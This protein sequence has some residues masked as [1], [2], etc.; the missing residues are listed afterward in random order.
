MKT[1]V[2]GSHK[3]RLT[4]ALLMSTHN[5][6]FHGKLEK[7]YQYFWIEKKKNNKKKKQHVIKSSALEENFL[8]KFVLFY[9]H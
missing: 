2:M 7:K 9:F 8:I 4:E 3:K 1:Y 5:V 6:R